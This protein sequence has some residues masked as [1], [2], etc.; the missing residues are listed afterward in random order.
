L[1]AYTEAQK[2]S[3]ASKEPEQRC[4]LLCS[5]MAKVERAETVRKGVRVTLRACIWSV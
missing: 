3:R 5:P 2:V 1:A 4:G